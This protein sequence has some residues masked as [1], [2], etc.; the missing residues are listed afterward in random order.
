MTADEAA[1]EAAHAVSSPRRDAELSTDLQL[2]AQRLALTG[3]SR[4]NVAV[5]PEMERKARF[6]RY[7]EIQRT[8][9]EGGEPEAEDLKWALRYAQ[10]PECR[11]QMRLLEASGRGPDAPVRVLQSTMKPENK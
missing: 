9:A 3:A 7:L 5:S 4:E 2:V 8:L 11:G 6:K 10:Q 1:R